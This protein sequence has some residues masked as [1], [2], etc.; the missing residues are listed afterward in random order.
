MWVVNL[1]VNLP[2]H[3]SVN[4]AATKKT[5]TEYSWYVVIEIKDGVMR[6]GDAHPR[7]GDMSDALILIISV[8]CDSSHLPNG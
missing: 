8:F 6:V 4:T 5:N 3:A 7:E 2:F 1:G